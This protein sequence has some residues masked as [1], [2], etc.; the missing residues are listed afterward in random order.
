MVYQKKSITSDH[1]NALSW[2][3]AHKSSHEDDV[4]STQSALV[5]DVTSPNLSWCVFVNVK[6]GVVS[7]IFVHVCV[8]CVGTPT[9]ACWFWCAV[10]LPRASV[11]PKQFLSK[12][13]T[14][15]FAIAFTGE[16]MEG[17]WNL[18]IVP[19]G[20]WWAPIFVMALMFP[21]ATMGSLTSIK[22]CFYSCAAGG[23]LLHHFLGH[24]QAAD[25]MPQLPASWKNF[26]EPRKDGRLSRSTWC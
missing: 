6:C 15:W 11:L 3:I 21:K 9:W 25:A 8:I 24:G 23:C 14:G 19:G 17:F 5:N 2:Y 26:C 13:Y 22:W 12:G 18:F 16:D 10:L 20:S 4:T 1:L 7:C